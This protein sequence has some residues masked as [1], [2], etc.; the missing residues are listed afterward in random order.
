MAEY[1]LGDNYVIDEDSNGDLVIKDRNGSNIIKHD[2]SADTVEVVKDV[3]DGTNVT[4]D[5]DNQSVNTDD[6]TINTL[7]AGELS[8]TDTILQSD[9]PLGT[10]GNFVLI[11]N[12]DD[13]STTSFARVAVKYKLLEPSE[14]SLVLKSANVTL[15]SRLFPASSF[16]RIMPVP[17]VS[18]ALTTSLTLSGC[19]RLFSLGIYITAKFISAMVSTEPPVSL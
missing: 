9:G 10:G 6:A 3:Y 4:A 12:P 2:H 16:V 1:E 8:I 17:P 13:T 11:T 7:E 15:I 5:V 14:R 18:K 19:C